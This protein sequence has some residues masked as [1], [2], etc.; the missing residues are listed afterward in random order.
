MPRDGAIIYGNPIGKLGMLRVEC[1]RVV[2]SGPLDA[3]GTVLRGLRAIAFISKHWAIN[4]RKRMACRAL[5]ASQF[6]LV[7]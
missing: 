1:P 4:L 3:R 7:A 2:S 6:E 5:K